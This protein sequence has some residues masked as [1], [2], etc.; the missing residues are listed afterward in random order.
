MHTFHIP[1][2]FYVPQGK[3]KLLSPEHLAQPLCD[4]KQDEGNM[5]IIDSCKVVLKWAQQYYKLAIPLG[6]K[7]NV[8]TFY[9]VPGILRFNAFCAEINNTNGNPLITNLMYISDDEDNNY[10]DPDKITFQFLKGKWDSKSHKSRHQRKFT[11]SA[12]KY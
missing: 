6:R 3:V 11:L 9:L 8:A 12:T 10:D 5:S 7:D 1:N 4:T 2:L